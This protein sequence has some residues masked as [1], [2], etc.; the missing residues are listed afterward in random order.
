MIA[1][2]AGRTRPT[3]QLHG[4]VHVQ[5]D[6]DDEHDANDPERFGAWSMQ[7]RT[8]R[9]DLLASGERLQVSCDMEDHEG[10]A[11][12]ARDCHDD[13]LSDG[14]A[15]KANDQIFTAFMGSST[16]S[17]LFFKAAFSSFVSSTSMT[18]SRPFRPSLHGTPRNSPFIPY[19]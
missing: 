17:A 12:Q 14:R 2:R 19:S 9:V 13:F 6:G 11:H 18:I 5:H 7:Q 8:V 16:A 15:I 3:R 4:G 10:H 1:H